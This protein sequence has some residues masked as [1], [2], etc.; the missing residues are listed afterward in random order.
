MRARSQRLRA[1]EGAARA[2]FARLEV[3]FVDACA[4]LR[5][6]VLKQTPLASPSFAKCAARPP[7][8]HPTWFARAKRSERSRQCRSSRPSFRR[9]AVRATGHERRRRARASCRGDCSCA[10]A[11]S[12]PSTKKRRLPTTEPAS[13]AI[14]RRLLAGGGLRRSPRQPAAR[15]ACNRLKCGA[16]ILRRCCCCFSACSAAA[17]ARLKLLVS[18]SRRPAESAPAL[19][20]AVSLHKRAQAHSFAGCVDGKRATFV[21]CEGSEGGN[22]LI[23]F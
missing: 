20:R 7:R 22:I 11:Q 23:C 15:E 21:A 14:Q 13:L 12:S 1:C 17:A 2:P 18:C 10:L 5:H 16:S 4:A 8:P 19:Q 9:R 6:F 3:C